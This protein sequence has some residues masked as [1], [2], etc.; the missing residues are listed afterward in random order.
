MVRYMVVINLL[1]H[2]DTVKSLVDVSSLE[3]RQQRR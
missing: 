1:T 3:G 2:L